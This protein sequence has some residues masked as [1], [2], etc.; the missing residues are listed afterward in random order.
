MKITHKIIFTI[1]FFIITIA[2]FILSNQSQLPMPLDSFTYEDKLAHLIAYFILGISILTASI[3]NFKNLKMKQII[4]ITLL[5]GFI[6]GCTDEIHQGYVPGR[7]ASIFDWLMDATG[8][9]LS[10]FLYNPI[11]KYMKKFIF[12]K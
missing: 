11:L 9:I 1:P 6:Y 12:F 10:T 8:I 2:I 5:I 7:D 3:A 4:I